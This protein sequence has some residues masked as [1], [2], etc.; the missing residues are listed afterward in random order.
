MGE[1]CNCEEVWQR[2][3]ELLKVTKMSTEKGRMLW[4]KRGC[5]GNC[6]TNKNIW[7]NFGAQ[8][9]DIILKNIEIVVEKKGCYVM[10]IARK[11]WNKHEHLKV[12]CSDLWKVAVVE[13]EQMLGYGK[14]QE[15]YGTSSG[16]LKTFSV[17]N[18]EN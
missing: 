8:N 4:K 1:I 15:N 12:Q 10:D 13:K 14:M 9:F 7:N 17:Q 16:S 18:I 6:G 11:S 5:Y 3:S 2:C